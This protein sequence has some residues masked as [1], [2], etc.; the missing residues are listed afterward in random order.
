MT[1]HSQPML[2]V[3][4]YDQAAKKYAELRRLKGK[5]EKVSGLVDKLRKRTVSALEE[6]APTEEA[7]RALQGR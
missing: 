1:A 6:F 3:D 4:T 7:L 5:Q 2:G